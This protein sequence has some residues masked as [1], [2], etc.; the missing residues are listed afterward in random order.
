RGQRQRTAVAAAASLKPKIFLLDEPTTGQDL[1]NLHRLMD[2]LCQAIREGNR[3]LIFATHHRELTEQYA[4]R[5]LL[6]NNGKLIFDGKPATAFS[7]KA[8]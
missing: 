3:T 5:I 6:L 4:D 2:E 8:L 7:D 1:Q